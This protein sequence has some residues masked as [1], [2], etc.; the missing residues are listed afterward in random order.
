MSY[1]KQHTKSKPKP[2]PR[3]TVNYKNCSYACAFHPALIYT[4]SMK[5]RPPKHD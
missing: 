1:R 2:K 4:E 3:P 5:K